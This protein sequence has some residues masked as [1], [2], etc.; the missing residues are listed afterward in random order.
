MPKIK[1]F[2]PLQELYHTIIHISMGLSSNQL[3]ARLK[4]LSL[5]HNICH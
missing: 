5:T 1:D 3:C 2:P 4:L